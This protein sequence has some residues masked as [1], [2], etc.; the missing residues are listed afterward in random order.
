[1]RVAVVGAKGRMGQA[2]IRLAGE[3]GMEV[4]H[5]LDK[6]DELS[7]AGAEAVIDFSHPDVL[8]H[9]AESAARAKAA[10]VSGTTGLDA[11]AEAALDTAAKTIPVLW[12]PNMSVGILVLGRLLQQALEVLGDAVDVEI[13]EAHHKLKLDARSGTAL[14]LLE[15]A[16][17]ARANKDKIGVVSV[18]GG[19]VIG[20]HTVHLLG[21]G[22]RIELM[23]RATSRDLFARGALRAAQALVG[24][25][26]RRYRL[27]D[28]F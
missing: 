21:M 3:Q 17:A 13:V 19:D 28:L 18:R 23:H 7:F 27:V 10:L 22:E 24:K 14:R 1:M 2:V 9:V 20:D 11:K 8:V 6:G 4:I 12:E 26:A 25:P 5:A 15:I 16:R